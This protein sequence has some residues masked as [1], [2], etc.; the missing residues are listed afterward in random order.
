MVKRSGRLSGIVKWPL[1]VVTSVLL[2]ACLP[3]CG[4]YTAPRF[5]MSMGRGQLDLTWLRQPIVNP[6]IVPSYGWWAFIPDFDLMFANTEH[7]N[8]FSNHVAY[9]AILNRDMYFRVSVIPWAPL[10][11]SLAACILFWRRSQRPPRG[12][13]TACGYNL[14]GNL[15]GVCPECG[16]RTP[17][18][19]S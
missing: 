13:C 3:W 17:G 19:R 18:V 4:G 10:V 7:Q 11:L 1:T 15:S 16:D 5:H 14:T 2:F 9:I 6:V 12:H 8:R